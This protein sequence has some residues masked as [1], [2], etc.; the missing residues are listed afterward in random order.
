MI[1]L[2]RKYIVTNRTG[3]TGWIIIYEGLIYACGCLHEDSKRE[4]NKMY[5][6]WRLSCRDVVTED[7][8]EN[9]YMFE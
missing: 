2:N 7:Y 9:C 5:R 6:L 1:Q 8:I 4:C 3:H